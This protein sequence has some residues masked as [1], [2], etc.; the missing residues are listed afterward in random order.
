MRW[1]SLK[2]IS[3]KYVK[4]SLLAIAWLPIIINII[5]KIKDIHL[6]DIKTEKPFII[7]I[8]ALLYLLASLL[9]N[10][11]V[12]KIIS[13]HQNEIAYAEW[14]KNNSGEYL[15]TFN[16]RYSLLDPS[17]IKRNF[18]EYVVYFPYN[19]ARKIYPAD[20]IAS[21]YGRFDFV[22]QNNSKIGLRYVYSLHIIV[23]IFMLFYPTVSRLYKLLSN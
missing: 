19:H 2:A 16:K 23:S 17:I 4:F 7:L 20:E 11:S 22:L 10:L 6:L 1:K 13:E 21:V 12:P 15:L 9:V 8:G 5:R 3:G 14:C 18:P